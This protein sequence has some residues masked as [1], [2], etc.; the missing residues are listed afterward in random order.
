MT[1][2]FER[3][4]ALSHSGGRF[5][6]TGGTLDRGHQGT[7]KQQLSRA[8]S[9]VLQAVGWSPAP[10]SRA[11]PASGPPTSAYSGWALP[12]IVVVVV[13]VAVDQS[14]YPIA[15]NVARIVTRCALPDLR[16][17]RSTVPYDRRFSKHLCKAG[18]H[19][20]NSDHH[21]N[22]SKGLFHCSHPLPVKC[23]WPARLPPLTA[24]RISCTNSGFKAPVFTIRTIPPFPTTRLS[25][26]IVGL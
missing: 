26:M 8:H 15:C 23:H 19:H 25:G 3:T 13:A 10:A 24:R 16:T 17:V 2:A 22:D 4:G 11:M 1:G 20:G 12:A 18:R 6:S 9:Q 5:L 21:R 7:G 14:Q